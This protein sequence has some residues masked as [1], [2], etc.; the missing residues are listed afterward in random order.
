VQKQLLVKGGHVKSPGQLPST[1]ISS[2]LPCAYSDTIVL[3]ATHS[4]IA[5]A[6]IQNEGWFVSDF[7]VFNYVLKGRSKEQTWP[8]AADPNQLVQKYGP[9]LHGN[10]YEERKVSLGMRSASC[11][12]MALGRILSERNFPHLK[13][14][15]GG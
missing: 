12:M 15:R 5:N 6:G 14:G 11:G 13:S 1:F 10:L 9:Y 2:T 8:R 3:A 4:T 7:Y